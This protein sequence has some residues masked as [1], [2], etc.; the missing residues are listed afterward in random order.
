MVRDH[1]VERSK[2]TK[3][4]VILIQECIKLSLLGGKVT[5]LTANVIAESIY[6]QCNAE[7]NE[8]LLLDALIDY[9]KNN[10][11]ISLSDQQTTVWA[12]Q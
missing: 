12:D 3:R 10:N 1:V 11:A 9:Q 4:N 5:E 8:Y 7:G 6:A 2:D